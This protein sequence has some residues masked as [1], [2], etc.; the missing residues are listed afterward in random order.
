MED[1]YGGPG[2]AGAGI[3]GGYNTAVGQV[4]PSNLTYGRR[5]GLDIYAKDEAIFSFDVQVG[6]IYKKTSISQVVASAVPTETKEVE[7]ITYTKDTIKSL[8]S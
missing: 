6:A 1:Y 2:G 7:N 3:I 8:N 4:A 5:I